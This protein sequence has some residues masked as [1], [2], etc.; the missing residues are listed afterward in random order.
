MSSL[1]SSKESSADGKRP[2]SAE[3]FSKRKS[4]DA[5]E[6]KD[7]PEN[8]ERETKERRT[9]ASATSAIDWLQG[10]EAFSLA[11]PLSLP[12]GHGEIDWEDGHV[13]PKKAPP[14]PPPENFQQ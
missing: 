13:R 9:A 10:D 4:D 8:E 2:P 11:L 14:V 5:D 1:D 3:T 7:E 6:T 12:P